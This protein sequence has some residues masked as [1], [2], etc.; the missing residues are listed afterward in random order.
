MNIEMSSK[1]P[2]PL[3]KKWYG[4]RRL[5]FSVYVYWALSAI[6]GLIF[7]QDLIF[8]WNVGETLARPWLLAILVVTLVVGQ[9]IYTIVG[10][11]DDRPFR[12]IP[13]IIF[14]VFNGI[15]ETFSFALVFKLGASVGTVILN[16]VLPAYADV[17]NFF[18]GLLFFVLYGGSIHAFLWLKVLPPHFKETPLVR[19]IRKFRMI[20]EVALVTG[21][22]LCFWITQDIWTVVFFHMIVDL[23]LMLR[24][25]PNLFVFNSVKK[26]DSFVS[27]HARTS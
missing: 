25:R 21:W 14:T 16:T 27:K 3:S 8:A 10:R 22:S 7:L 20:S 18:F 6:L 1:F 17:G 19:S 12:L 4:T 24:V 13:T 15:L 5:E 23:V 26:D 9:I 11:H 2:Q